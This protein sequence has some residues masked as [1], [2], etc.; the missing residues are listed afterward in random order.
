MNTI[1]SAYNKS[2][3]PARQGVMGDGAYL[4]DGGRRKVFLSWLWFRLARLRC[5]VGHQRPIV[6]QSRGKDASQCLNDLLEE[7]NKL[8]LEAPRDHFTYL[9]HECSTRGCH[10]ACPNDA[11]G[12]DDAGVVYSAVVV[13]GVQALSGFACASKGCPNHPLKNKRFCNTHRDL[14]DLCAAHI[15]EGTNDDAFC[16]NP[17]RPGF[18]TCEA[19]ADI[20][21]EFGGPIPRQYQAERRQGERQDE[22][23]ARHSQYWRNRKKH[24]FSRSFLKGYWF[25]LRPCGIVIACKPMVDFESPTDLLDWLDSLFTDDTRPSYIIYDRACKVRRR[26]YY[27]LHDLY[28]ISMSSL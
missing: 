12:V 18:Q 27:V 16:N 20:E 3:G 9:K 4:N 28:Y 8:H 19:H 22:W 13:D 24:R 11:L 7:E 21:Q 26:V 2:W 17:C 5:V 14:E 1:V 23:R 10:G 6:Y 25:A 15:G